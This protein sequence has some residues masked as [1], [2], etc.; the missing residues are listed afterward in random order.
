MEQNFIE[1]FH[2]SEHVDHFKA[3]KFVSLR[4]IPEMVLPP[5]LYGKDHSFLMKAS[6]NL[7][8]KTSLQ[9]IHFYI[10]EILI[11]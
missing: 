5:Q 9:N 3:I 7:A 8:R 2:V 1:F 11:L 4:K 10:S 6:L